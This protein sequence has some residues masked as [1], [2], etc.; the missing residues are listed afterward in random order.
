MKNTT[1]RRK[2]SGGKRIGV[3]FSRPPNHRRC[4]LCGERFDGEGMTVGYVVRLT[5][6]VT[7]RIYIH[8][9]C[10]WEKR[11]SVDVRRTL[12]RYNLLISLEWRNGLQK[13]GRKMDGGESV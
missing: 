2:L 5:S 13:A 10:F 11:G 12:F 3:E 8:A 9:D 1:I 7:R 4:V 6:G